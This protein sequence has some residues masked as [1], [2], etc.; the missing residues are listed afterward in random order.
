MLLSCLTGWG[1][2]DRH[3]ISQEE[4]CPDC[5]EGTLNGGLVSNGDTNRYGMCCQDSLIDEGL[6]SVEPLQVGGLP[7][8]W[9]KILE[10]M[11]Y[12]YE[13]GKVIE[14]LMVD[15]SRFPVS[16]IL[17]SRTMGRWVVVGPVIWQ[18]SVEAARV[19]A[20][21]LWLDCFAGEPTSSASPLSHGRFNGPRYRSG[22]GGLTSAS[23]LILRL[24][25]HPRPPPRPAHAW[26]FRR[27]K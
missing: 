26:P 20:V 18:G 4:W 8:S 2:S 22:V 17:R 10:I 16:V 23:T 21:Q 25:P 19:I 5:N 12:R 9:G 13:V 15:G 24:H 6:Y 11:V 27:W 7:S 14:V 1:I 3:S